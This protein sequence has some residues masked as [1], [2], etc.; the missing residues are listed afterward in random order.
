MDWAEGLEKTVHLR[1]HSDKGANLRMCF[2][3]FWVLL[4]RT[5][6]K[7]YPHSYKQLYEWIWMEGWG[8][9]LWRKATFWSDTGKRGEYINFFTRCKI[10]SFLFNHAPFNEQPWYIVLLCIIKKWENINGYIPSSCRWRTKRSKPDKCQP[11]HLLLKK[12]DERWF[13]SFSQ[14]VTRSFCVC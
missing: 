5:F 3:L 6:S 7:F 2:L 12:G 13:H 9:F 14:L 4:H 1:V 11:L 8:V 10:S